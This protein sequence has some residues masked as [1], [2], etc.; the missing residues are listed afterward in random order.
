MLNPLDPTFLFAVACLLVIV[1]ILIF[2][3]EPKEKPFEHWRRLNQSTGRC[4][5]CPIDHYETIGEHPS[6]FIPGPGIT[7]PVQIDP[8]KPGDRFPER[9]GPGA[10]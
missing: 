2:K 7:N 6:V 1:F 5:H 9:E 4:Y 10:Q 3:S 8:S